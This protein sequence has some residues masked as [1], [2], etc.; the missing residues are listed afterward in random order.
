MHC[1]IRLPLQNTK[2]KIKLLNQ[3]Q[4]PLSMGPYVTALVACPTK[5]ALYRKPYK[6]M[7]WISKKG[8]YYRHM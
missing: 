8:R 4:T 3:E 6:G 5:L 7:L 2:S 1:C